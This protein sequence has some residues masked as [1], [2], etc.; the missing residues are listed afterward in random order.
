MSQELEEI[1]KLIGKLQKDVT[2][3]KRSVDMLTFKINKLDEDID[4]ANMIF[5]KILTPIA[6]VVMFL[7]GVVGYIFFKVL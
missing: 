3:T 2:D 6:G 5:W 4:E 1:S 7:A